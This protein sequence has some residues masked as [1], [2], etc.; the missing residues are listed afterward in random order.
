[1]VGGGYGLLEGL[2]EPKEPPRMRSYDS[3]KDCM[4]SNWRNAEEL[5]CEK[6]GFQTDENTVCD[7]YEG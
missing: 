6:Y 4:A 1:M 2:M 3:C 7:G 5:W